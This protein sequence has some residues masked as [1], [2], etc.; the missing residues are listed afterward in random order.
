[1]RHGA[2]R[3][4]PAQ[5][6]S[7][8]NATVHSGSR[9]A[10]RGSTRR[11][12]HVRHGTIPLLRRLDRS[13]RVFSPRCHSCS[14]ITSAPAPATSSL[15]A[16]SASTSPRPPPRPGV[17]DSD[18]TLLRP[19]PHDFRRLYLTELVANKLPVHIA[20]QPAGHRSL[21]TTQGYVAVYPQ[22]V[23]EAERREDVEQNLRT[24][25]VPR[26]ELAWPGCSPT[27]TTCC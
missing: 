12:S 24:L 20:A 9:R 25:G 15:T 8:E 6:R 10:S 27:P 13:E 5:A 17:R 14:S 11:S 22:D 19:T 4:P 26:R 3:Q 23:F 1:M 18:G 21:T 7:L 2:A 16:P